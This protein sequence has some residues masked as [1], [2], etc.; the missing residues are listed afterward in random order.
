MKTLVKLK[1]TARAARRRIKLTAANFAVLVITTYEEYKKKPSW[2][3]LFQIVVFLGKIVMR[4]IITK[5]L[6]WLLWF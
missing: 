5:F 4:L 1:Q 6:D 2:E 3:K